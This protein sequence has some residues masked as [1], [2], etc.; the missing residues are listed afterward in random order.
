MK[1]TLQGTVNTYCV[2]DLLEIA[3]RTGEGI[4]FCDRHVCRIIS[5]ILPDDSSEYLR[6]LYSITENYGDFRVC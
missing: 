1:E 3:V 5:N 6:H 4:N 2:Q